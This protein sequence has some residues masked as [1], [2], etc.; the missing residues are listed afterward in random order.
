MPKE[1]PASI[2]IRLRAELQKA[3]A[4]PAVRDKLD[5]SGFEVAPSASIEAA[6]AYMASAQELYRKVVTE[7]GLDV[8]Q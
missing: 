7:A 6:A 3:L 1:V 2:K 4:A 8:G 5:S